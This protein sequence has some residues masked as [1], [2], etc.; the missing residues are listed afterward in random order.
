MLGN[1]QMNR[2]NKK[3]DFKITCK[4]SSNNMEKMKEQMKL[5]KCTTEKK[6]TATSLRHPYR[7]NKTKQNE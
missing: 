2:M 1:K 3:N 7:E 6:I 4:T 5:T